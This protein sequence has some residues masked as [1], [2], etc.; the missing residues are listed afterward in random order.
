MAGRIIEENGKYYFIGYPPPRESDL[1]QIKH[2]IGPD[3]AAIE[4]DQKE[5]MDFIKKKNAEKA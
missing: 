5:L 3:E 2:R 1:D 4:I